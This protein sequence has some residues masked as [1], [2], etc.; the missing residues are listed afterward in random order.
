MVLA[1]LL[2]QHLSLRPSMLEKAGPKS[3]ILGRFVV[4]L[5]SPDSPPGS[6]AAC[7]SELRQP[8]YCRCAG[9]AKMLSV[10]FILQSWE[11]GLKVRAGSF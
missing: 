8:E 1:F 9:G 6:P 11:R 10:I 7:R 3:C 2:C 5:A 4:A